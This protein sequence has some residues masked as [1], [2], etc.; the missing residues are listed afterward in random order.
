M[1]RGKEAD[2]RTR[3]DKKRAGL[4]FCIAMFVL[5]L[6]CTAACICALTHGRRINEDLQSAAQPAPAPAPSSPAPAEQDPPPGPPSSPIDFAALQ[7]MYPDIYAY[8]EIPDTN[9]SY[10]IFQHPTD[11]AYYLDHNADGTPGRPAVI[12]T[13]PG[14]ARD[15]SDFNTILYGHDMYDGT[16]F[17][18]LQDYRSPDYL[19]GHRGIVIYTPDKTRRYTIC[20]AVVFDDRYLPYFYDPA[21]E[22]GRQAYL[23]DIAATGTSGSQVLTDIPVS[24]DDR[25]ITLSTC[26]D[27]LPEC[28][29]LVVAV[30]TEER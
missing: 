4:I 22:E 16:M 10:P 9:V 15:F 21:T 27:G 29:Y 1:E 13:E 11:A 17:G 19:A 5:A 18:S 26:V 8:I 28:R 7:A 14:T 20:A 3:F 24:T 23:D 12:Y 2:R 6:I 30:L 25:L